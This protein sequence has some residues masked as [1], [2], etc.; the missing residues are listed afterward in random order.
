MI[1][2]AFALWVPPKGHVTYGWPI[3][4]ADRWLCVS[5]MTRMMRAG[6]RVFGSDGIWVRLVGGGLRSLL[7]GV[8][9]ARCQIY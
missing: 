8:Q 9:A 1:A 5:R 2:I 3:R 4:A 6:G 7:R